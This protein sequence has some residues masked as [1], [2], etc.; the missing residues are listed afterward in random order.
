M[1]LIP[2]LSSGLIVLSPMVFSQAAFADGWPTSVVGNWSVN[3]NNSVGTLSITTQSAT[4]NC[5]PITG[6]IFGDRITQGF[7][8]PFSGRIHFLR[9][10]GNTFQAYT[11]NLS[12]NA[13][14][15]RMGGLF[16]DF[17]QPGEYSFFASSD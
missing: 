1:K 4:G 16:T 13:T 3:A 10:V 12:Q 5:R 7:Y 6:S 2:V 8:C 11:A 17:G 9:Q 14:T 15:L